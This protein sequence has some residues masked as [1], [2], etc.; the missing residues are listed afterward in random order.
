MNF[1]KWFTYAKNLSLLAKILAAGMILFSWVRYVFFGIA[2]DMEE[3][4]KAAGGIVVVFG[5]VDLNLIAEKF[6]VK[7]VK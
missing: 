5:T 3:V 1:L 6:G 2:I 4:L 7:A